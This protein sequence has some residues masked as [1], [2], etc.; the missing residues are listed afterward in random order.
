MMRSRLLGI[1]LAGAC[2][3][4]C[5]V[6]A[7]FKIFRAQRR[8]ATFGDDTSSKPYYVTTP[9]FYVNAGMIASRSRPG[10][11]EFKLADAVLAPHIG[12]LYALVLADILKR[13]QVLKGRRALFC[14]GT[15]EHGMKASHAR[16]SK[17]SLPDLEL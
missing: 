4:R 12:H 15:D 8:Y 7:P 6:Q 3:S 17:C 11:C 1:A 9:I 13:W 16:A 5:S 2:S 10:E 14:T